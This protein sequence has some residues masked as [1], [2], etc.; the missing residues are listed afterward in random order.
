MSNPVITYADKDKDA[1]IGTIERTWRALDA[2]EVKAVVNALSALLGQDF[3]QGIVPTVV[4]V[5]NSSSCVVNHNL[6][7]TPLIRVVNSAGHEVS[8]VAVDADPDTTTI[9]FGRPFTGT[10]IAI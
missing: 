9:N 7:R 4:T 8:V 3:G 2:N 5:T 10:V 1:P 6:D